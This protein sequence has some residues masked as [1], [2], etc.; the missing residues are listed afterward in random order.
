MVDLKNL[1]EN[2]VIKLLVDALNKIN[3]TIIKVSTHGQQEHGVD[4]IA[5]SRDTIDLDQ[6][7]YFQVK[8]E[9]I[10]IS[11][12]RNEIKG[13]IDAMLDFIP[14]DPGIPQHAAIR[15]ILVYTKNIT[16]DARIEIVKYCDD[17]HPRLE[18]IDDKRILKIVEKSEE[19]QDEDYKLIKFFSNIKLNVETINKIRNKEIEDPL[20]KLI[21]NILRSYNNEQLS[22]FRKLVG[23]LDGHWNTI[24]KSFDKSTNTYPISSYF[25]EHYN[26]IIVKLIDKNENDEYYEPVLESFQKNIKT[27]LSIKDILDEDTYLGDCSYFSSVFSRIVEKSI[28]KPHYWMFRTTIDDFIDQIELAV[29]YQLDD[30]KI[31]LFYINNLNSIVESACKKSFDLDLLSVRMSWVGIDL[32]S[33]ELEKSLDSL[34]NIFDSLINFE[35]K[36]TDKDNLI[37]TLRSLMYIWVFCKTEKTKK[38]NEKII[39][40]LRKIDSQPNLW[41]WLSI[42]YDKAQELLG[43]KPEEIKNLTKIIDQVDILKKLY[44]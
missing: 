4:I 25:S 14:D 16:P 5:V 15:R 7:Y 17:R 13:Q 22:L 12:W 9:N 21:D 44:T 28:D 41:V 2:E 1:G 27:F 32:A 33:S 35:I 23:I 24:I 34:L 26:R 42:A 19:I 31:S 11:K 39:L 30:F 10:T 20:Q 8:T 38:C 40:I 37:I 6:I 43:N 18:F 36:R 3:F 29:K